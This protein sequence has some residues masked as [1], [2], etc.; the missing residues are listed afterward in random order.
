M[1]EEAGLRKVNAEE[2]VKSPRG[3]SAMSAVRGSRYW[4]ET[5]DGKRGT[6]SNWFTTTPNRGRSPR[7]D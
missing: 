5:W 3:I 1:R 2:Q 6:A 7:L 4:G